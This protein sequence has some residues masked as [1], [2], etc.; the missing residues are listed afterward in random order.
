MLGELGIPRMPQ[1]NRKW[2]RRRLG[3]PL[4]I[5]GA[6]ITTELELSVAGRKLA[7]ATMWMVAAQASP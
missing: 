7:L 5:S 6:R 1:V 3:H 2:R 4:D